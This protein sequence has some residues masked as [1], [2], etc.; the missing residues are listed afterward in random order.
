MAIS[1]FAPLTM[2]SCYSRS[3]RTRR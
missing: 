1:P 2:T 3:T